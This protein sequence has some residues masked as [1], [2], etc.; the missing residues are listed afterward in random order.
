LL[1][2]STNNEVHLMIRSIG[3]VAVIAAVAL[4]V[5]LLTGMSSGNAFIMAALVAMLGLL[6]IMRE[7]VMESADEPVNAK[8]TRA[9][10]R[11]WKDIPEAVRRE[12]MNACFYHGPDSAEVGELRKKHAAVPNFDKFSAS[13]DRVKRV[14][15]GS[16]IDWPPGQ[17][18]VDEPKKSTKG[19]SWRKIPLAVQTEYM[20]TCA[21][22]G[23]DDARVE[24]LRRKFAQ[25]VGF[26]EFAAAFDKLKRSVGGSGI[27]WPPGQK[28]E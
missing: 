5:L 27:E 11:Q 21:L 2:G 13:V 10:L 20:D 23:P 16:G 7:K 17:K 14:A 15:G 24:Q 18:P 4:A 19:L 25:V 22:Y 9:L 28:P 8:I 12:Y 6:T 3:L 26:N 1:A